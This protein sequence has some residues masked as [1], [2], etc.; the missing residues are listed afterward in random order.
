MFNRFNNEIKQ[1]NES[2][3]ANGD[4]KDSNDVSRITQGYVATQTA[5]ESTR[6]AALKFAKPD[7]YSGS[8]KL[9][10]SPKAKVSAKSK[11]FNSGERV[12][13]PYTGDVL[14]LRK[15]EAKLLY[16]KDWQYHLA[17]SDH[18][19]PLEQIFK[20]TKG[21]V[22]NTT[23]DI[24]IAANSDDNIRVASRKFN[25]PKRSRTNKNYVEDQEY[26]DSKG[27]KLTQQG[28]NQAI[29]DGERAEISIQK[30]LNR[31]AVNNVLETGNQAGLNGAMNAGGTALTISGIMNFVAVCR[32]EKCAEE[33]ITDIIQDGGKAA[34]SGYIM[35]SGLTVAAHSLSNSSSQFIQGL[36]NSN[37]PG[38]VI[39]A[40]MVTGEAL[41]KWGNGE[42]TTQEC[43]IEIGEKGLNLATTGYSMAVGQALI[44]IPIVGAAI[45]ALVGSTLTGEYYHHFIND[46]ERR[47]LEHEERMRIISQCR[48]ASEQTKAYR[49]E[50]ELYLESYFQ[51][52]QNCFD[53]VISSMR[54]SYQCGDA[55][56]VIRNANVITKKLGGTI[57]YE[58]VKDY[59][60]FLDSDE[61][62]KL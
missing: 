7:S 61:M 8:R 39:T 12:V 33:A 3:N 48:I 44:P 1:L 2:N 34:A 53:E 41:S 52:Y 36:V 58:S 49:D 15:Q 9:Y 62:F 57:Q 50:L 6:S 4:N 14:V 45:G 43:L 27:V 60:K 18:I 38:K 21:N 54:F 35:S 24:K 37:V 31:S 28:K 25:N 42:I 10:D 23:E 56:S 11:L 5:Q 16:G 32:G 47:N 40:V 13:D 29:K 20:D 17:E 22:W 19:K 59:K 26:L 46:L 51:D 55:D 30:Q